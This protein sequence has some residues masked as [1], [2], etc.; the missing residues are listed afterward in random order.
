MR[1]KPLIAALFV[2]RAIAQGTSA[3]ICEKVEDDPNKT[4]DDELFQ[5]SQSDDRLDPNKFVRVVYKV[6]TLTENGN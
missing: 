1:T 4:Q 5:F 2:S 3:Q 6:K